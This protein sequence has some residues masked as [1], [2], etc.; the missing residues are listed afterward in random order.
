[1]YFNSSVE[2]HPFELISKQSNASF[3]SFVENFGKLKVSCFFTF[4]SWLVNGI[5]DLEVK[6]NTFF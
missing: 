3:I 1:M 5:F 2:I 4:F 6:L